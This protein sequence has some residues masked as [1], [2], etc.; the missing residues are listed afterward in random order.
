MTE[1]GSVPLVEVWRGQIV[2]SR[3]RGHLAAVDGDGRLVASLGAPDTVTYLRSSA[4]PFQMMPLLTSGAADRFGFTEKEIA[5]ACASHNGEPIHTETVAGMLQKIGLDASYLKCGV[6]DPFSAE[7]TRQL[8]ER[9][10]APT[11]LHNNCSGKHTGFLALALHLGAPVE[12]YDQL[13]NPVQQLVLQ[14]IAEF[15]GI[16]IGQIELAMDGCGAPVFG[17]PIRAM[18]VMYARFVNPPAEFPDAVR[19]ACR[20]IAA[21]MMNNPEM[22]GGGLNE[23]LDTEIMRAAAGAIVSKVGAEGVYTAGVLPGA[24]WPHGLGLALKIEDGEDRRARPTVV[25][26]ALRQLGVLDDSAL[27]A[28]AQY[29]RFPIRN[30]RGDQVGE[31]QPNFVLERPTG[32]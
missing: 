24:K 26:E 27:A 31:V 14:T 18:A 6:H 20:R 28:L 13:D 32:S 4:K 2:E 1:T 12:T 19:S 15:S 30:H 29:A 17:V 23:R 5:V 3:H 16:P 10:E 7:V 11:V 25:I 22:I 9:G 21:A 8:R